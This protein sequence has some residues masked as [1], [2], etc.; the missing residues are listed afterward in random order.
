MHLA[1]AVVLAESFRAALLLSEE[2]AMPPSGSAGRSSCPAAPGGSWQEPASQRVLRFATDLGLLASEP[3]AAAA[4]LQGDADLLLDSRAG[5]PKSPACSAACA[6]GLT[7]AECL[8][9]GQS[10]STVLCWGPRYGRIFS[11]LLPCPRGLLPGA[12][13][14]PGAGSCG[15]PSRGSASSARLSWLSI[16]AAMSLSRREVSSG[17]RSMAAIWASWAL[18]TGPGLPWRLYACASALSAADEPCT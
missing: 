14:G 12:G 18:P 4:G 15:W 8:G 5:S 17:L 3:A 6:K 7:G 16:L 11:A 10:S 9:E 1:L 2:N 13:P